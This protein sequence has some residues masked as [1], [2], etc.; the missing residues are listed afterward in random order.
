MTFDGMKNSDLIRCANCGAANRVNPTKLAQGSQAICG[1]CQKTLTPSHPVI[2]TDSNFASVI[3]RS[4]LPVLLDLWAPW[5]G[6]CRALSPIIE[7]LA[8][9]LAGKVKVGKL[10]VDENPVIASRFRISSIPT[11]LILKNGQVVDRIVG[12]QPKQEIIRRLNSIS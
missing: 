3:E 7:Q 9:E 5:C 1:K 12:A 11:L 6:P 2:V 4:S 10:N 8:T